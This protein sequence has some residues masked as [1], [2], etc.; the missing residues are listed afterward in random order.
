MGLGDKG[1]DVDRYLP[2]KAPGT[3]QGQIDQGLYILL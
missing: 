2:V 1:G 3:G